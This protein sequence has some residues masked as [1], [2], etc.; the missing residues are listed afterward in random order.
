MENYSL[1][2]SMAVRYNGYTWHAVISV[3]GLVIS[4]LM[5]PKKHRSTPE[6]R[7]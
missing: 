7:P 4:Y 3:I 2:H 6:A 1:P 5:F